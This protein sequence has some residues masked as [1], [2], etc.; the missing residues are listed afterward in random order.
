MNGRISEL[1]GLPKY[2]CLFLNMLSPPFLNLV[3]SLFTLRGWLP[4]PCLPRIDSN[5]LALFGSLLLS[6]WL[7]S[8][9]VDSIFTFVIWRCVKQSPSQSGPTKARLNSA[10]LW[11]LPAESTFPEGSFLPRVSWLHWESCSLGDISPPTCR[12]VAFSY[13][14]NRFITAEYS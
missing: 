10:A 14:P 3:L 6:L 7:P 2:P 12:S 13:W 8:N 4:E 11:S 9:M 5:L 1:V